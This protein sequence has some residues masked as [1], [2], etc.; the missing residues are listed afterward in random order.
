MFTFLDQD[1]ALDFMLEN[2][3]E[4]KKI[5]TLIGEERSEIIIIYIL[6]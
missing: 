6:N 2:V 4:Q 5:A 3:K 1:V